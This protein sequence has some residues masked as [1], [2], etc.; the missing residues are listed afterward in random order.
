MSNYTKS[1]NFAAKDSL[2][3]GNANKVVKGTEINTEF[4]NIATAIATKADLNSPTLVTPNLGTPSAAVL[5][6][7]TG[8][9]ISTGVSGLGTGVATA[10]AINVGSAGAPVVNGG[11]LGTPSSGTV[12]NLTGTA[13]ININ[14]TVGATTPTTGAFTTLTASGNV[15]LSG[16]TAN[17]VLYLNGSK[18]AT[19]GSALTFDGSNLGLGVTPSAWGIFKGM[20]FPG[21][22]LVGNAGGVGNNQVALYNNA[23]F[24]GANERYLTSDTAQQFRSIAGAFQWRQAPSGTA[25]N[26]ITFTQAMTLDSSGNLGIGTS[27]PTVRLQLEQAAN[28]APVTL[29]RLNNSGTT[30]GGPGIAS[31]IS[32]TAGATAL[33][34]IQGSNF[35]SGAA[36]LQLSGDGTNAQATL[37]SS[38]NLGLGVTPSACTTNFGIKAFDISNGCV[39]GANNDVNLVYNAFFN[40][41]DFIYKTTTFAARYAQTND[42]QHRWYTAPSGTAG[43]AITFTQ[44][45]TLDASG[46]LVVGGTSA[47]VYGISGKAITLNTPTGTSCIYEYTVNGTATGYFGGNASST[48]LGAKTSIPIIF[49]TNDTERARITSSG[50]LITNVNGTAPT[51]STNSTMSFE[52]TSNTSLKIVVRGTDGVTRS[53]SLLLV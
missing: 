17:G 25:G 45:M 39:Y 27:S 1:T 18:V 11:A 51:L 7:A 47:N 28:S 15:T 50:D 6:N 13:S 44:A 5:T 10:L 26:A 3:S 49:Y 32:F 43:N 12:T 48:W 22:A 37:D 24:D 52:L 19:S 42:G 40:G 23:Y 20:Q 53:A 46:N 31:R 21:G 34:F 30:A 38:G 35:A 36:G 14:G 16:G 33:G 2:P 29:L 4:D 41:T 9:P 8:L